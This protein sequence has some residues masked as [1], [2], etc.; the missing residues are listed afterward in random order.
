VL[1]RMILSLTWFGAFCSWSCGSACV[2]L[3]IGTASA[4]CAYE[5]KHKEY[6]FHCIFLF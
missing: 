2:A 6:L 1:T 5:D 4:Q 3:V